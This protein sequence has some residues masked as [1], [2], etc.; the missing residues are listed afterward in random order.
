MIGVGVWVINLDLCL[1]V[2]HSTVPCSTATF[3][4]ASQP[5]RRRRNLSILSY[6]SRMTGSRKVDE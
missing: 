2:W 4:T 5:R 3:G 6:G 1:G